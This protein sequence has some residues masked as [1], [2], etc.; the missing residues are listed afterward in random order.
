MRFQR[1]MR[2]DVSTSWG[3][4]MSTSWGRGLGGIS[5][6]WQRERHRVPLPQTPGQCYTYHIVAPRDLS[7]VSGKLGRERR[8]EALAFGSPT[9]SAGFVGERDVSKVQGFEPCDQRNS[10]RK[11]TA[12]TEATAKIRGRGSFGQ[13]L[14]FRTVLRSVVRKKRGEEWRCGSEKRSYV[15]G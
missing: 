7:D 1:A 8:Q 9:E 10:G 12:R 2:W 4:I 6:S 14:Q 13:R 3:A 15:E 5:T 11:S